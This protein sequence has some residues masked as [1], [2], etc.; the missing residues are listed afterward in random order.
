MV[1][2]KNLL[3]VAAATMFST[4]AYAADMAAP[5]PV[6]QPPPTMY[7][8]QPAWEGGWYLR[9]DLGVGLLDYSEFDHGQANPAFAWPPSWTI[10]QSDI[11]DTTI[12]GGGVGYELNNFLRFDVTGEYRTK[13]AFRVTG[14]YTDFCGGGGTCYDNLTGNYSAAV[15]MA[16]AYVDLGTWWCLTPYIGAGVG[17]AYNSIT[18]IQDQG[19]ISNGT[20]GFGFSTSDNSSWS[21]AWNVQAGLTYNVT[22]TFKVD[23]SWRY[24]DLGSPVSAV[25]NCQNTPVCPGAFYTFK[26]MTSQDFR[27][28]VRWMLQPDT[29]AVVMPQPPLTSRG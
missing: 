14:S 5:P 22:N 26:D 21:L 20:Q 23:I 19:I 6:Y 16:N 7:Q 29:P 15:F 1:S 13:A 12:F 28:G 8:P 18:G 17:G 25:V 2:V 24:L 11:Q 4:A 27:I 9:G 10:V 3:S